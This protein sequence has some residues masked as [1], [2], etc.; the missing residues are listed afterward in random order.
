MKI[1]LYS[2]KLVKSKSMSLP[3]SWEEADND[4]LFVQAIHVYRDRAHGSPAKVKTRSAVA[5]STK[6]I[7]RQKGTGFARHGDRKA[8]IFVGGG[9][10][11]GPKGVK[12]KLSLPKKM[13]VRARRIAYFRKAAVGELLALEGIGSIKKTKEAVKFLDKILSSEGLKKNSKITLVLS[14]QNE[15]LRSFFRNIAG[16]GVL[17]AAQANA[18]KIFLGG[19][20]LVDRKVFEENKK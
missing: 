7:H 1:K 18:Y 4:S 2:T 15:A 13:R 14:E 17:S 19:K 20:I 8:N 5:G 16:L 12:R 6:K 10:A 9:A 3:A 11:H